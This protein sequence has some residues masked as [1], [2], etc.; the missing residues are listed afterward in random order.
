MPSLATYQRIQLRQYP[1]LTA[2]WLK[3]QVMDSPSLLGLGELE[4]LELDPKT[5]TIADRVSLLLRDPYQRNPAEARYELEIQLGWADE[6]FIF[7]AIERWDRERQRCPGCRHCVVLAAEH[8][9]KRYINFLRLFGNAVPV[10][11]LE[12][13]ALLVDDKVLLHFAK[14]YDQRVYF[15]DNPPIRRR[16]FLDKGYWIHRTE[17]ETMVMINAVIKVAQEECPRYSARFLR[18]YVSLEGEAEGD[19]LLWMWTRGPALLVHFRP[20]Q[21]KAS[22]AEAKAFG[23]DAEIIGSE[24]RVAL[25]PSAPE[26]LD[27]ALRKLVRMAAHGNLQTRQGDSPGSGGQ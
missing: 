10:V 24:L 9:S 11:A 22:L 19:H 20:P 2:G 8:V 25:Y 21:L 1:E 17:H 4:V 7:R 23:L 15:L 12:L 26:D 14:L 27:D 18:D 5:P 16:A 3:E 6:A 13:N